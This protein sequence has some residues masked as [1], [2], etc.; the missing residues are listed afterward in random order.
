MIRRAVKAALLFCLVLMAMPLAAQDIKPFETGSL[1]R[2]LAAHPTRPL[3]LAL[4]SLGCPHCPDELALLAE[5]ARKN[6]DLTIVLISTDTPDEADAIA[7]MLNR[8]GFGQA[9]A[10]V[11]ADTFTERLRYEIDRHW[12]GELPRTYLYGTDGS[13]T[14][15]SGKLTPQRLDQWLEQ[16]TKLAKRP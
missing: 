9:E 13:V 1:N 3:L 2:I 6:P 7:S 12:R 15:V 14:G 11:F 10:W 5:T 4:W 16:Q 8:H